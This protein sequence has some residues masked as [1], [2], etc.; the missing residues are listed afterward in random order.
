MKKKMIKFSLIVS[1]IFI[2]IGIYIYSVPMLY[3]PV[4]SDAIIILGCRVNGTKPSEFLKKRVEVG[5]KLYK[6]GYGKKIIV[7]GGM[8]NK[9][10]ISEAECMKNLLVESGIDSNKI[11]LEDKSTNTNEN[12]KFSSKKM[13]E[14]NYNTAIVVSNN[15]HLRRAKILAKKNNLSATFKGF[16]SLD[17]EHLF[18]EVYGVIREI[19][20]IIKDSLIG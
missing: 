6:Q 8:G 1:I 14:L 13:K 12:I 15:F 2:L 5:E 16:T 11:I 19:P 3:V 18:P 4:K 20:A 7:S 9:E 10:D 17:L